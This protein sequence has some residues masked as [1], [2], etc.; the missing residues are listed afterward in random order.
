M[1]FRLRTLLIAVSLA[2]VATFATVQWLRRPV[3]AKTLDGREFRLQ[4]QDALLYCVMTNDSQTLPRLLSI[5]TYDLN[6]IGGGA[7]SWTL[8]QQAVHHRC[9]ETITIL[10]QH[11]ADPNLTSGS[12]PTPLQIAEQIGHRDLINVL[13]EFGAKH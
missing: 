12:T 13:K 10:L 7:G 6:H 11:G 3:N 4:G 5:D 2:A 9:I 1:K 8:L